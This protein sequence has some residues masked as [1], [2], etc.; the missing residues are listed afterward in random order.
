[1]D[2][3]SKPKRNRL[4]MLVSALQR[5]RF[6]FCMRNVLQAQVD[7]LI[8]TQEHAS[9]LTQDTTHR[10]GGRERRDASRRSR[11]LGMVLVVGEKVEHEKR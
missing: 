1:M 4:N 11:T 8:F 3:T 7:I 6:A 5:D 10:L 2:N 9:D